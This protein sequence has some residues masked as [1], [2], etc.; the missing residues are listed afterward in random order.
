MITAT[1]WFDAALE[2][3]YT[4]LT[5]VP[6]SYLTP[7]INA[8]IGDERTTY[9]GA[10]SEGE[11]I[12]IACGAWLGGQRSVVMC[13]NSGFG[14]TVNPLTSLSWT[15]QIPHLLVTTWRGEPGRVDEPQHELMGAKLTELLEA[16]DLPYEAFPVEPSDIGPSLDRADATM[17]ETS[18]PFAFVMRKGTVAKHQLAPRAVD[19][20]TFPPEPMRARPLGAPELARNAAVA[21]VV[22]AFGPDAAYL[23]TTGKLGRE[24]FTLGDRNNQ[25]YN[26]GSMGCVSAIGL[27]VALTRPEQRV[28]V[29]DGDGSLLMKLGALA[30]IGHYAPRALVHVVFDNEK[31]E[32]TGGQST[33]SS[34]VSF[35][36]IAAGAGYRHAFEGSTANDLD[37]AL[38]EIRDLEGPI[39]VHQKVGLATDPAL[40]RPDVHPSDVARRFRTWLARGDSR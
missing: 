30:T 27:G 5:G 37:A 18:R 19:R 32:S 23:A 25:L 34:T 17:R 21:R 3:G 16:V 29:L 13:Q 9:V 38:D 28:V 8:A 12:A 40:G 11:A 2:R 24:L 4:F 22:E 14:N 26:V 33:V 15:F 31:H 1:E 20:G 35:A 39:L 6:C 10:A 36:R 7:F